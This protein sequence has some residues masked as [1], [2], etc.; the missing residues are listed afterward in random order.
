MVLNQLIINTGTEKNYV[1][2]A[3]EEPLCLNWL[4][5]QM[6]DRLSMLYNP[7]V[8]KAMADWF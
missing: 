4:N 1:E 3:T 8:P 5:R 2:T 6:I 7:I